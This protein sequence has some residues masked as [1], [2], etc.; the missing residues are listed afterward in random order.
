M[1]RERETQTQPKQKSEKAR[2][3]EILTILTRHNLVK[4][5][6]PQ[7]L[8]LTLEDLGPTF[9]KL[10]QIMSMRSDL[11]PKKYCAALSLLRSDVAPMPFDMVTAVVES[12]LGA[13]LLTL[14]TQFEET[15]L[16]SASIAQAH[17]AVLPDGQHVVVK[18]QRPGIRETMA[19]DIGLLK[20]A[21]RILRLA[22]NAG[23]VI[24][25]N[26]VLDELWQVTQEEMNFLDEA[27][28]AEMFYENNRDIAYVSCPRII[29]N[30]TTDKV[31]VMEQ[32]DGYA[33]DD[34]ETL[35]RSGYDRKEIGMKLADNYIKQIVDDG[36]FHAD[37]HPGNIRIREG[38]IVWIDLGMMGRLSP[39]DRRMFASAIQAVSM[40]DV[41]KVKDV[42]LAM[43]N[44]HG[45]I[46]HSRLYTDIEDLLVHYGSMDLGAM[47]LSRLIDEL[48]NL[49]GEHHISLPAGISLLARGVATI[50]GVLAVVCPEINI[51][52]IAA[53]HMTT[54]MLQSVN[55]SKEFADSAKAV[56]ASGRKALDIPALTADLLK[57]SIKGQTKLSMEM[58][59]SDEMKRVMVRLVNHL[60]MGILAAALLIGSSLICTTNMEPKILGIPAL[61]LVGYLAAVLLSL[62]LFFSARKD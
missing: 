22:S 57:M 43:S 26:M 52:E 50:E 51:V 34:L 21:A 46:N 62:L 53:N 7:K 48:L 38:Q 11:L 5:L 45:K 8:R 14:F 32:I 18:V 49:V 2:L 54:S 6:T 37:P 56:L 9:I 30:L 27:H 20:K 35:E 60:I 25:F 59:T 28:N 24:D 40:Q 41:G 39:R 31:L 58:Q 15:P 61:G 44:H 12:S 55:W 19:R 4:G 1:E 3:L 47:N 33:I 16:G 42:I 17:R 10:G 13:P 36:F 29:R 23:E